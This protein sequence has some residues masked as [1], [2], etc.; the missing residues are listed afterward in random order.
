MDDF[1]LSRGFV[2][3]TWFATLTVLAASLLAF[4]CLARAR[5]LVHDLERLVEIVEEVV[6]E[7]D[8]VECEEVGP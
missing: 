8:D 3:V 4:G 1:G 6:F 5:R 2:A 7:D